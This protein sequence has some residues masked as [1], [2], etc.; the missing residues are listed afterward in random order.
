[1]DSSISQRHRR[2]L[3]TSGVTDF[4]ISWAVMGATAP[5]VLARFRPV[6][7]CSSNLL[8]AQCMFVRQDLFNAQCMFVRQDLFNAQC[9]FVRQDLLNA[10]C[11]FVRQDLFNT[12]LCLF[13]RLV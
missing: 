7:V 2:W 10:Q 1:M 11:M 4:S 3:S 8:N 5:G 12:Q 6:Y 13:I 9:M